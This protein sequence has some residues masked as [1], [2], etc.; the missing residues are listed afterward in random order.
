MSPRRPTPGLSNA[1]GDDPMT[2]T[3]VTVGAT[4]LS[5]F[6]WR[7]A[8]ALFFGGAL[9]IAPYIGSISVL[10]PA[11][12]AIVAPEDKVG[13]V[14][15]LSVTG[16]VL[17]LVANVV[18][19]ALS[20]T[21][22][23]RFGA[24]TPWIAGGAL[25]SAVALYGFSTASTVL[26]LFLWWG[27]YLTVINAIIAPMVATIA[28]QVP[29]KYRGTVSSVYGLAQLIGAT[30][31]S[32][33]AAGFV[34]APSSGLVV[35]SVLT[36]L[37]AVLF[38]AIAPRRSNR[39]QVRERIGLR[40]LLRTF[41]PPLRG[42]RDFYFALSGKFLLQA[43]LY[44]VTGFQ[45]YILTDYIKLHTDQAGQLIATLGV[46]SLLTGVVF[47]FGSGPLSDRVG[48]RKPFVIGAAALVAVGV[49]FPL[50]A[51]MAWAMMAFG[52]LSGIGNGIYGSVD[53]ALNIDVLPD[54]EN[55]AKDL[56]I[57][58]IANSGGQILGPVIT[59]VLV[60]VSG[61]YQATFIA[62]FILLIGSA[63]LIMPIR[64]VR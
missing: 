3:N 49:A 16:A 37:S 30:G 18:F 4:S 33:V 12:V 19:G 42:A 1:R 24:R 31:S 57:L 15:I 53:Q 61:G 23:S 10:M 44:S 64:S 11:R 2:T 51:P 45:L 13:I 6:N 17:A 58:N 55:A 34:T 43:A 29:E 47:G 38:I 39:D 36:L 26:T 8:I 14:T 20:D 54:K 60:A 59:S 9:W 25:L 40:A 46:I 21:T 5:R 52:V 56:G 50:F 27:L 28:D 48:R 22:R 41:R 32:I 63:L 35:F 7:L 62:A